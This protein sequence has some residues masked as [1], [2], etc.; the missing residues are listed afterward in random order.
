M[1]EIVRDTEALVRIRTSN[2]PGNERAAASWLER[3]LSHS[4][5]RTELVGHGDGRASLVAWF[6]FGEGPLLVFNTHL[7]VVPPADRS[8]WT[9]TR[10][11]GRLYGRGAADAK[12]ILAAMVGACERL[13]GRPDGVAGTLMLQAVADEEVGALGS[14]ALAPVARS[15]VGAVIGEPTE[16]KVV[17][18]SRG[19]LRVAVTFRGVAVHSS[20]P[21]NGVNAIYRAARF[22]LSLE[23]L[24][25][26]L[27]TRRPEAAA[28]A[29]TV[30]QGGSKVN[31]V[32]DVC[33]VHVDRRLAVDETTEQ[34]QA[35]LI[36]LL[37]EQRRL[38]PGLSW[39]ITP[40]G[41]WLEPVN[42]APEGF[43]SLC[44]SAAGG[45]G[46]GSTFVGGTDAPHFVAEGL[47]AVIVGPGS[48]KEAH[49]SDESIAVSELEHAV[50]V[51]EAIA[52]AALKWTPPEVRAT[53]S[54]DRPTPL[55]PALP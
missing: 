6:E 15:A 7:D 20:A 43:P 26:R 5:T 17:I 49:T 3:R 31:I 11:D 38:D 14:K 8:Q 22:A 10:V 34:A 27:A 24:D 18:R 28:C 4:A 52:R 2:P 33:V 23:A 46:F 53:V 40:V 51:Y 50:E 36:A 39:E 25:R 41:T 1:A 42:L 30:V 55:Q 12:G 21:S 47:P 35:E 29:A 16:N 37:E 48:L 9:P 19:A 44:L 45:G 54:Q 32:P 13:R